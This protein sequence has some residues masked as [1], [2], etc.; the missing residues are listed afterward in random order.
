MIRRLAAVSALAILFSVRPTQAAGVDA[1]AKMLAQ[2]DDEWSKAAA[3][4]DAERVASFYAEDAIAY[5]PGMP[6]AVGRAAAQRVWA[7]YFVN[8][9]FKISWKS[10]HASVNGD[11]GFTSGAYEDSY[12]GTDGKLVTET[13]KFVCVWRKQKDGSWKAVHDIWNGDK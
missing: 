6:L 5:P 11:L 4:R 7:S 2:L 8:E 12:K 3:T 9:T 13:G 10:S 1:N